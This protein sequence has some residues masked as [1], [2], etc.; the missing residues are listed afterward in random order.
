M[1]KH[2]K[3]KIAR[4]PSAWLE[5]LIAKEG[6]GKPAKKSVGVELLCA[7]SRA[8]TLKSGEDLETILVK[9][10][11]GDQAAPAI[12]KYRMSIDSED[13]VFRVSPNSI[14]EARPKTKVPAARS[15]MPSG[16]FN[17]AM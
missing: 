11:V 14:K 8:F 10:L 16:G 4:V 5:D 17:G 13:V 3:L 7:T 6:D 12:G 9:D 1:T 2:F 15:P